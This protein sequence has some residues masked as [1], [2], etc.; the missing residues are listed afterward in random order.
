MSWTV[1]SAAWETGKTGVSRKLDGFPSIRFIGVDMANW[2]FTQGIHDIG[3]G[4]YGYVQP[5]GTWGW[6]NAGLITDSGNSL[7]VDTLMTVPLTRDMLQAFKAVEGGDAISQVVNTH[8]NPDHFMGN[9]VLPE[10]EFISTEACARDIAD[11]DPAMLA[12]L[13]DN[14]EKMGDAG[15]FLFETMGRKFDYRDAEIVVPEPPLQR[16]YS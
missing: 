4:L 7:L 11:F 6:S 14:W 15:E 10:A 13:A 16:N 8:A 3:N 9:C 5:D 1:K 12:G 2:A